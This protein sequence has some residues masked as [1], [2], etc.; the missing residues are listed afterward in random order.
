M[1]DGN[2]VFSL[3]HPVYSPDGLRKQAQE[4]KVVDNLQDFLMSLEDECML[5]CTWSW[6]QKRLKFEPTPAGVLGWL[7][8]QHKPLDVSLMP[9]YVE[10]DHHCMIHNPNHTI[11]YLTVG[12]CGRVVTFP[13][14]HTV[15][16][17]QFH[18]NFLLALSKGGVFAKP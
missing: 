12:A 14:A 3:I 13:V 5:S 1:V 15:D 2:Y 6:K 11:C 10:F 7:G 16:C 18:H 4:E 8:Q 9:I 17:S